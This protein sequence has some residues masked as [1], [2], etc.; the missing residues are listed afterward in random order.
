MVAGRRTCVRFPEKSLD[1]RIEQEHAALG[2][3]AARRILV[4]EGHADVGESLCAVFEL[5]GHS[6][7]L[8]SGG[9]RG[10]TQALRHM[11]DVIVVD[12]G[13][14]DLDGCKVVQLI[15]TDARG[16]T[17]VVIAYSGYAR[18]EHEALEA[19]CD[20]FVLKPDVDQLTTVVHMTREEAWHFVATAGPV[21]ARRR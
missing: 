21:A 15:R 19:G 17:P 13:L 3:A 14:P 12:L 16:A 1:G 18:R 6:A 20:A 4:I 11:P 9:V 10:V 8:A 2:M 7:M 5:L